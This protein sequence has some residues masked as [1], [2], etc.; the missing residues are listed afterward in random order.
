M[1]S[2]KNFSGAVIPQDNIII[3]YLSNNKWFTRRI[4]GKLRWNKWENIIKSLYEHYT[5]RAILIARRERTQ[6]VLR[7]L[8][9]FKISR[10]SGKLWLPCSSMGICNVFVLHSCG[11]LAVLPLKNNQVKY[12]RYRNSCFVG[13]L[14]QPVLASSPTSAARC[15]DKDRL[16][17]LIN[18]S[19]KCLLTNWRS[20]GEVKSLSHLRILT[21]MGY[22]GIYRNFC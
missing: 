20:C 18:L 12:F 14:P 6:L 15:T 9:T 4:I 8:S 21:L 11:A 16:Y 10:V 7:H 5:Y 13:L 22:G 2:E 3:F 1:I 17:F 19:E